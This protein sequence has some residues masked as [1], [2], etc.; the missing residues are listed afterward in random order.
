MVCSALLSLQNLLLFE[1]SKVRVS[2]PW[3]GWMGCAPGK[4][5]GSARSCRAAGE[6]D[7]S[8]ILKHYP[9]SSRTP[10]G[11]EKQENRLIK[12]VRGGTREASG[13]GEEA[14]RQ[15]RMVLQGGEH[16]A[17]HCRACGDS[18]ADG[19]CL[20]TWPP[21]PGDFG[22]C[23][24][25]SLAS[26]PMPSPPSP[27]TPG[28]TR[29]PHASVCKS[30]AGGT[31]GDTLFGAAPAQLRCFPG[32]ARLE[33]APTLPTLQGLGVG[34][35]QRGHCRISEK[36]PKL[37]HPAASGCCEPPVCPRSPRGLG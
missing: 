23:R 30:W 18:L 31:R 5:L 7:Q 35:C 6:Q 8:I 29:I 28:P 20:A 4:V 1:H 13:R 16:P 15:G 25:A 2:C 10:A 36:Y 9:S 26:L 22:G 11:R 14:D 3:H 37:A 12:R 33:A 19:L 32:L 34:K 24:L 21:K 27:L 17:P